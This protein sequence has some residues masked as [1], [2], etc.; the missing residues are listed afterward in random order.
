M[1]GIYAKFVL[2]TLTHLSMRQ[3]LLRSYR[4]RVA[5]GATGRVLELGFGSGLNL[6]FYGSNVE[7]IVGVDVSHEM[8]T[9]AQPA[10]AASP[11]KVTLVERS[12]ESLP[13]DAATFDTVVVTWALCCILDPIA[14][15]R[16]SRRVLK[17]G[18]Q[19]R[20]AEHGLSADPGVAKWQNRLTPLWS[21]C[22]GGC[23][24]N[25]KT[26][27]LLWA[28]GFE[29]AELSTGYARGLRP[30]TYMYEGRAG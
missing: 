28:A 11:R 23:H 25:R 3:A 19:L 10:V 16:E 15:L 14:A 12:A 21:L 27:D 5:S 9:I 18:G 4:E 22:A 1:M 24:L 17:P 2:P 29:I 26:D 8:L 7:E 20:F 6:P 30:F 13:F